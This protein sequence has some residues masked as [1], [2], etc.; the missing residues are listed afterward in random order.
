[1]IQFVHKIALASFVMMLFSGLVKWIDIWP[2]DATVLFTGITSVCLLFEFVFKNK[3]SIAKGGINNIFKILPFTIWVFISIIYSSSESYVYTKAINFFLIFITFSF[4]FMLIKNKRDLNIFMRFLVTAGLLTSLVILYLFYAGGLSLSLTY[5]RLLENGNPLGIP[6]YLALATP[7]LIAAVVLTFNK[8]III[9]T[10]AIIPVFA[11]LILSGRAPIL[12]FILILFTYAFY[13]LKLSRRMIRR[14]ILLSLFLLFASLNFTK[15]NSFD[16][17]IS[18]FESISNDNFMSNQNE[19]VD[20]YE[21]SYESFLNKPFIGI[22]LGSF[23]LYHYEK[24]VRDHPHNMFLEVLVEQ[25]LIGLIL[26]LFLFLPLLLRVL[27][28]LLKSKN[29]IYFICGA[30]FICES[31]NV[32]KSSSIVENRAYFA[33]IGICFVAYFLINENKNLQII[34][35]G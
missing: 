34:N 1:M 10:L 29:H 13:N 18:R 31:I 4:T 14:S 5:F 2:I 11:L 6:D 27:P 33:I 30:L 9:K 35:E 20:L 26:M 28:K 8:N 21:I 19:R 24:D 22:G 12:S 32:I 23:G 7:I 17:A 16:R 15:I 25:G 3:I